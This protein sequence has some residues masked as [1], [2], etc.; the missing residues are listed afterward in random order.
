MLVIYILLLKQ[1]LNYELLMQ[2]DN[3]VNHIDVIA[4]PYAY[5]IVAYHFYRF[6]F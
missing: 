4:L 3:K 1:Y 2:V 6:I 5:C